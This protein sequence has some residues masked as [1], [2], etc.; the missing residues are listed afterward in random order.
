MKSKY[1]LGYIFD[2][3][4]FQLY[5]RYNYEILKLIKIQYF[6]LNLYQIFKIQK[7][8]YY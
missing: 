8:H 3:C 7:K 6:V 1:Y 4:I 2:D 5:K